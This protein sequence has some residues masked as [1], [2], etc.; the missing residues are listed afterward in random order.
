MVEARLERHLRLHWALVAAAAAAEEEEGQ[1]ARLN[2]ALVVEVEE[3]PRPGR[4]DY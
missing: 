2:L 4:K 3:G 1:P